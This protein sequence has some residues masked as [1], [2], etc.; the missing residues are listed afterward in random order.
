MLNQ[1]I[2]RE[3]T[4]LTRAGQLVEATALLQRMLQGGSAP[5][6]TSRSA[7]RLRSR[8]SSRR[9]STPR[10]TSSR[11]GKSRPTCAGPLRSG[12]QTPLTARRHEGVLRARPA[13]SDRARSAV[14][15][16]YRAR[17]HKVHRRHL[18]QRGGKPDLQAV[19]PKPLSGTTASP[20]RHASRLHPVAGRFRRRH[21]DELPGGRA[22]LLRRLS[23]AAERSQPVEVLE[24]VSHGRPAPRRGRTLADRRHHPPDHAGPC[25][26]S[27]AR[28]RR[29]PV[30]RRGRRRHHGRDV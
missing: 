24:L 22:E 3:A 12:T 23:R 13:R 20:G 15:I 11:R 19:H 2:V 21:P 8:G 7:A 27:E 26:R 10:P 6:P 5:R 25:D 16:G 17:G 14:H 1:D 4:R 18:Q 9:P 28:L 29:G 30:G